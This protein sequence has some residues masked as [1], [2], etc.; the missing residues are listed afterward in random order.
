MP[1]VPVT[2]PA[3]GESISEGIISR[4]HKPDGSLVRAGEP[5]FE[6]ET[7]KATSN[8]PASDTGVLQ[9]AV[10]EGETVAVGATVATIDPADP[11][12]TTA[13]AAPKDRQSQPATEK[14]AAAK[15]EAQLPP[16]R[17]APEPKPSA[18]QPTH[19]SAPENHSLSPAVRRLAAEENVDVSEVPASGKG[20][21]VTKGDVLACLRSPRQRTAPRRAPAARSLA[22]RPMP[23]LHPPRHPLPPAKP[24][25]A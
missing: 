15:A 4:W 5:L 6:L 7:D 20:G 16:A 23:R 24:A 12:A 9:I 3:V 21:R 10:A 14:P 8:V 18:P 22:S 11:A 25:S 2:V 19:T 13:P 17:R 1:S